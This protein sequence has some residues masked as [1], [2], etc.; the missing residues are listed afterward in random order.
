MCL[1]F[2]LFH[3]TRFHNSVTKICSALSLSLSLSVCSILD[4]L[5]QLLVFRREQKFDRDTFTLVGGMSQATRSRSSV[6]LFPNATHSLTYSLTRLLVYS[7]IHLHSSV[8]V[9]CNALKYVILR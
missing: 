8:A 9:V 4:G 7:F 2:H 6:F 1:G 3:V 5:W